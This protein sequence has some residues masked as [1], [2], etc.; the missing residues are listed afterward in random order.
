MKSDVYCFK[1]NIP[2]DVLTSEVDEDEESYLEE[3]ELSKCKCSKCGQIAYA[4]VEW[5]FTLNMEVE[6]E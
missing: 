2:L 4:T 5:M 3:H 1:C 6:G